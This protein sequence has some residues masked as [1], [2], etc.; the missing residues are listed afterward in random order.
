MPMPAMSVRIS[1]SAPTYTRASPPP[2]PTTKLV[3]WSTWSYS[4][5][6]GMEMKVMTMKMPAMRATLRD[7]GS[8][9][10]SN[11]ARSAC[12]GGAETVITGSLMGDARTTEGRRAKAGRERVPQGP[13]FTQG[14]NRPYTLR[15]DTHAQSRSWESGPR[16]RG[17]GVLSVVALAL[18]PE[19]PPTWWPPRVLLKPEGF[20]LRLC[21]QTVMPHPSR[22]T[23]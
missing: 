11:D 9:D 22:P 12:S 8:P 1:N 5:N 3:W 4:G 21:T 18:R 15:A 16:A 13:P 23:R 14:A 20:L 7:G 2:A 6:A 19:L 17:I 10:R